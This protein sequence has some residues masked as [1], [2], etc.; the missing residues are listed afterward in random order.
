M[1]KTILLFLG[2]AI[3][4]FLI[5]SSSQDKAEKA[6]YSGANACRICHGEDS[7]GNQSAIWEKSLHAKSYSVLTD[8]GFVASAKERGVDPLPAEDP[9]CLVCHAPLYKVAPS[10]MQEGVTC[11]ACHDPTKIHDKKKDE[12]MSCLTCHENAHNKPF[13]L[14]S[15][16]EKL[17]HPL[18]D[19][20][21]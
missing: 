5:S 11:G 14:P 8:S 21:K 10:I 15:A 16:W 20:G 6:K 13:D 17:K 12:V 2:L 18:P 3:A 9:G 4:F 7:L 19:K 1:K